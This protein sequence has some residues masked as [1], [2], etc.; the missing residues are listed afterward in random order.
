MQNYEDINLNKF[1]LALDKQDQLLIASKS[2]HF[3]YS[4][5]FFN[6]DV[7]ISGYIKLLKSLR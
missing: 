5:H 2:L 3:L 4:H 1:F 7:D 6:E